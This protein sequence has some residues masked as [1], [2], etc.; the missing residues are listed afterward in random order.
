LGFGFHELH[1]NETRTCFSAF[2]NNL[3][4][5]LEKEWA[6]HRSLRN[7]ALP[8]HLPNPKAETDIYAYHSRNSHQRF[9]QKL[10]W[11]SSNRILF[12]PTTFAS[13]YFSALIINHP[14]FP[15]HQHHYIHLYIQLK[16]IIIFYQTK[17]FLLY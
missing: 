8:H 10:Q 7:F 3:T 16:K 14:H 4:G 13:V 9:S 17:T 12:N 6:W 2:A 11:N 1:V 15:T 5:S